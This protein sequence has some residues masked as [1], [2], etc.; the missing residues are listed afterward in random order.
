M[1]VVRR[2]ILV[3][4]SNVEALWN[5]GKS[6]HVN[7]HFIRKNPTTKKSLFEAYMMSD[8]YMLFK[9]TVPSDEDIT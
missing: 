5:F 4:D 3:E 1:R 9:L 6:H 8:T 2:R 7:F